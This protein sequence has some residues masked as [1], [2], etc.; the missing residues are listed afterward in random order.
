ML[1]ILKEATSEKKLEQVREVIKEMGLKYHLIQ[2]GKRIKFFIQ[3]SNPKQNGQIKSLEQ[4]DYS[5]EINV[6]YPLASRY[7]KNEDSIVKVGNIEIGGDKACVIAG[8]CAVENR[9]Q[10]NDIAKELS[11]LGVQLFRGG[12]YKPRSSPY[13]FQGLKEEGLKYLTEV[14]EKFGLKVVTEVIN[15]ETLKEVEKVADILQI[16]SRN[17][18]NFDLLKEVGKS[19]RPILLKRGMSATIQD[20]LMSAEYI[21]AQGNSQVILCERGIRTFETATRN[22]LDL[23]AIPL[24]KQLTHLPVIVDPSHGTGIRELVAPMT[25]AGIAAG[26]HGITVEVHCKPEEALSDGM[27]SLTPQQFEKLYYKFNKLE[28]ALK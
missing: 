9:E 4:I 16:G 21:L 12:A 1:F 10:L 13:A 20:F 6:P 7:V 19:K 22:T 18:Q 24:L 3:N 8:P 25:F 2:D 27:Q 11:G 28:A 5:E 17:M 26:A 14:K 15:T 23:N